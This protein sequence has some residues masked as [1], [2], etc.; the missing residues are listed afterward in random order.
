[1]GRS[2]PE[3]AR[4]RAARYRERHREEIRERDRAYRERNRSAI[5]DRDRQWRADHPD[6]RRASAAQTRARLR[7]KLNAA[8]REYNLSRRTRER[9][10][11]LELLG[12]KCVRCGYDADWR[13]LQ[14][15]H[16][17]GGGTRLRRSVASLP[18]YYRALREGRGGDVQVLC[19]NCHAIVGYERRAELRA[20]RAAKQ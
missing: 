10:E 1:M 11:L 15:D 9:L 20:E 17:N 16:I 7:D 19:A 18:E 6:R 5:R 2:S 14:V 8:T 4:E 12:R 3:K 13:A